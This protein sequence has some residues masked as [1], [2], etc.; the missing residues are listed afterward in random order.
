MNKKE[1]NQKNAML[2]TGPKTPQGLKQS[3]KNALKHG[4][5]SKHVVLASESLEDYTAL[6]ESMMESLRPCDHVESLL[7]QRATH[8]AWRLRR[9]ERTET[10]MFDRGHENAET[11]AIFDSLDS[12]G[13]KRVGIS[14]VFNTLERGSSSISN[15]TKYE[16]HCE[17]GMYR[18]LHDLERRQAARAGKPTIAP[19]SIDIQVMGNLP[20]EH[21]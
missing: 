11:D 10:N 2:S 4:L 18:A 6:L 3:S 16:A 7:V 19:M 9:I 14:D 1:S 12:I 21:E 20:N 15:L 13:I 17:R 5:T 8:Y